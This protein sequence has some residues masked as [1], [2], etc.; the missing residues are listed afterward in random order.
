MRIGLNRFSHS[1]LLCILPRSIP[2]PQYVAI[3][4]ES[5]DETW[6]GVGHGNTRNTKDKAQILNRVR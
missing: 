4:D 3:V 1:L 2:A 5:S 6:N